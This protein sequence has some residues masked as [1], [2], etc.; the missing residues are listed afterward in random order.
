MA[1]ESTTE[2]NTAS[3]ST[4]EEGTVKGNSADESTPEKNNDEYYLDSLEDIYGALRKIILMKQPVFISIEGSD[5]K[6][7]S[8][9]T[10]ANLKNSSFFLDKVVPEKGND[11]IRSGSRFSVLADSQGVRIEFNM[12][13]RLKYQPTNEQYRVEFPTQVLYLQRRTAYRV[14]I[15][16]AHQILVKLKMEDGGD[17]LVGQ[18]SDLSSSGFKALFKSDCV[19]RLKA[20]NN[21]PVARVKFN[22]QNNMDC[23]LVARHVVATKNGNTQVGFAFNMISGMGQRFLDRLIG[24]LQWEERQRAEQVELNK[25]KNNEK[26][27]DLQS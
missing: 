9:I 18:L 7:S 23:S 3:E 13:G 27:P 21:I 10:H 25:L 24:E 16:P 26:L 1:D 11:L 8:A 5:E 19:E 17:N 6:F 4:A 20:N 14:M 22:D 12:T 15:P 2:E